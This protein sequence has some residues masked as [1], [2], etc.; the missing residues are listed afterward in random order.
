MPSRRSFGEI[1]LDV[2]AGRERAMV[3]PGS[4]TPFRI[5]I[6][7]D[8][9][10]RKNRGLSETG[11]ALASR[12][13]QLIDRDNFDSVLAKIAPQLDLLPGGE[14]A[15]RIA[16]KFA[17]LDD[18]HPD[19][20][21][22]KVQ[23]FQKLRQTRRELSD[24]ATFAK[25]ASELG[26]VGK[27]PLAEKAPPA[28]A[29][30][31]SKADVERAVSGS[32]LDEMIEATEGRAAEEVPS[33]RGD[34]WSS[35]V[36]EMVAPHV[37]AKADPRQAELVALIDKATSAQMAALL[38][39]PD[40][41]A[42]E[43]AW[44]AVFFLVR[45]IETDTQLKLFL[46]D[47]S[48]EELA[49][50][51]LTCDDLSATGVYRLLVEKSVGTPGA[52]PWAVM[53][54]NFNFGPTARDI[55]LLARMAKV[56]AGAGA[57]FIAGASPRLLT[58]D[59]VLEL[60]DTRQWKIEMSGETAARWQSL[61]SSPEARFVGLALPRF[62]LRLP[63]G[64]ETEPA[65][66]FQFEEMPD[67]TS[68]ESYLWCNSAFACALLLAQTYAEQGWELQPGTISEIIGLPVYV[69]RVESE[70]QTLPC[71]EV[72][73]T[74]TAAEKMMEKGF[75]PLASLKDQPAVRLL[76]FQAIADPLSS[77]AGR[78]QS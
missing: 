58:C 43:A 63:Y 56:A 20:L 62:L 39:A 75:M 44:R 10:G 4:E 73:M 35:L 78:W 2:N 46:I 23:M 60:P 37:V 69:Y 34:E 42:L 51:L 66:L 71:A 77:L 57:P 16:L 33:K 21:F 7:G 3:T 72:L 31:V 47:V 67:P 6:L 64:K 76:R 19:R 55:E 52:E 17:D 14:D 68:H 12:R 54:G 40:F 9:S 45:N 27:Q 5:A 53:A 61:R 13:P 48:K 8:F 36:K 50:D 49:R 26:L 59:S 18:F 38:R 11:D 32:L 28:P 25:T 29:R 41:Q 74:Q 15:F 30:E 70:P 24:P 65:D 22:E 1:H